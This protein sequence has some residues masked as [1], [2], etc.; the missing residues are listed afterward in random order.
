MELLTTLWAY[1]TAIKTRTGFTPFHLVYGREALLPVEVE[2]TAVK[3]L[4]KLL[5]ESPDAFKEILLY[6]QEVQL[7]RDCALAHYEG[8]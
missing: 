1:R 2:I 5:D 4:E 6:L 8:M 7:D 3:M